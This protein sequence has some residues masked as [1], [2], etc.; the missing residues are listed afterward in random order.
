MRSDAPTAELFSDRNG[1]LA[2]SRG[3]RESGSAGEISLAHLLSPIHL[4]GDVQP[5][6]FLEGGINDGPDVPFPP[7]KGRWVLLAN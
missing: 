5:C 6:W 2:Q 1:E 7:T 4:I 3:V